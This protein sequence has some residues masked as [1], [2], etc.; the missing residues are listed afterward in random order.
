MEEVLK[1]STIKDVA[2]KAG[3]AVTTVSRVLNNRGYISGNMKEKV[4]KAMEELNY[5]PNEI[6]R[7][8]YR[9]KSNIIGFIIPNVSHPFFAE[10]TNYI[11][12]YA[13]TYGYKILLCNSELNREKEKEYIDLLKRNQVDGIIMGSHTLDVEEYLN[14]SLPL[15]TIDRFIAESIPCVS[16]DNYEGGKLATNLLIEKGCRKIAHICGNLKIKVLAN[17]RHDA[18]VDVANSKNI[19]H[20]TL[21]TDVNVFDRNQ[22]EKL[23]NKLFNEHPDIDG[24]FASSDVIAAHII[25]ACYELKKRIPEDI[26]IVG[27]DDV[28]LASLVTPQITTIKQ[29]L[30]KMSKLV[31]ELIIKQIN[32]EEISMKNILPVSLVERLTT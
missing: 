15:V 21:E 26:K 6:A 14:L 22:Y 17:E 7:S 19:E 27:Y 23:I 31:I 18:F 11:E 8:L 29:P 20:I 25:K 3:V 5:Q 13:Y 1:M 16:S 9:K 2:K 12:Y 4:Y 28:S 24:I 32:E 30:D 10:L